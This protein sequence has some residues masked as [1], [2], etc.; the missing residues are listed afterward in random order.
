MPM[1]PEFPVAM[2]ACARIG[3]IHSVVFGGLILESLAGRILD[4]KARVIVVANGVG[5]DAVVNATPIALSN[6]SLVSIL[7]LH[8]TLYTFESTGEPKGIAHHTIG[9]MVYAGTASKYSFD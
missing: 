5:R 8:S 6:G 1:T 4:S 2:L 9:Y 3:A 7:C